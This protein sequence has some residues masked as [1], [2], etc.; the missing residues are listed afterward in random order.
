MPDLDRIK[1]EEKGTA[2]PCP[3]RRPMA[4]AR[5][6]SYTENVHPALAGYW[7]RRGWPADRVCFLEMMHMHDTVRFS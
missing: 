5:L 6:A 2:R 4:S 3:P 1:Q 7:N